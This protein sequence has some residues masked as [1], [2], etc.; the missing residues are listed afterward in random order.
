METSSC[1]STRVFTR[2]EQKKNKQKNTQLFVPWCYMWNLVRIGFSGNVVWKCWR[3]RTDDRRDGTEQNMMKQ[4]IRFF[5]DSVFK[6]ALASLSLEHFPDLLHTTPAVN[7]I[8]KLLQRNY[9]HIYTMF[10]SGWFS[11]ECLAVWTKQFLKE[12]HVC[13]A[14]GIFKKLKQYAQPVLF[15]VI[16]FLCLETSSASSCVRIILCGKIQCTQ[17]R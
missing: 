2:L 5:H 11:S 6:A 4:N 10:L 14:F 17:W 9:I 3:W 7:S 1:H 12:T 15:H 16:Y 8:L 13:V